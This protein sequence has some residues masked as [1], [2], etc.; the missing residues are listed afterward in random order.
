MS[1]KAFSKIWILVVIVAIA[2]GG[3]L[4]WQYLLLPEKEIKVAEQ[5]EV[6]VPEQ[7]EVIE[8]ETADWKT[9]RNK[10]YNY[11][12]RYPKDWDSPI[13]SGDIDALTTN[14]AD[15]LK[16][17]TIVGFSINVY[18][19]DKNL[20]LKDWWEQE[21]YEKFTV[22]YE[23]SYEGFVSIS[24]G[25]EA[26]KYKIQRTGFEDNCFLISKNQKVYTIYFSVLPEAKEIQQIISTFRFLE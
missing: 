14:D 20:S 7:E 15:F 22:K 8:D 25:I 5:E 1:Q 26:V 12:I 17:G 19:N 21:F 16:R 18:E 3:V 10:K 4:A 11:E 9:Y 2:A 24:P 23:Y 13:E 6:K